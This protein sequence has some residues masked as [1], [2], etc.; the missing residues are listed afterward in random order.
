M[1]DIDGTKLQREQPFRWKCKDTDF[2]ISSS[3]FQV[4]PSGNVSGSDVRFAGGVIGGFKLSDT[5]IQS[6]DESVEL[7]NTLHGFK[8]K[9]GGEL[10]EY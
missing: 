10:I 6:T 5:V 8:N 4:T 2:F 1:V 7:S 9:D 3:N